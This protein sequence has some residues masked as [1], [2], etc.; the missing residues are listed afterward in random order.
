MILGDDISS[1][2]KKVVSNREKFGLFLK[3]FWLSWVRFGIL[4]QLFTFFHTTIMPP[5]TTSD[6]QDQPSSSSSMLKERRFKLSR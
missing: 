5:V 3:Y 2:Q 4:I 6:T 1:N